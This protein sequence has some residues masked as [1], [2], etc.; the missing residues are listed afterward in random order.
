MTGFIPSYKKI[1]EEDFAKRLFQADEILKTCTGCPRNC[2]ADRTN[3]DLGTCQSGDK[4]IVSSFS[5]HFGEDTQ[6]ETGQMFE[7]LADMTDDDAALAEMKDL[8]LL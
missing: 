6:S 3:G 5:P 7:M 2:L 1:S 4:P 8:G